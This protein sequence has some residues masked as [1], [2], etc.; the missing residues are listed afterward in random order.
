MGYTLTKYI[1]ERAAKLQLDR[2]TTVLT[3]PKN[4]KA[5]YIGVTL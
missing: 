4:N 1:N 2:L 3:E 5:E